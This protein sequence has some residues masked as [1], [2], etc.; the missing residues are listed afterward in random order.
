MFMTLPRD[1]SPARL[2]IDPFNEQ[3]PPV[4]SAS[5]RVLGG[6][7][8]FSS[9]SGTFIAIADAAYRGLP[10]EANAAELPVYDIQLR[11]VPARKHPDN[12]PPSLRMQAGAGLICGMMDESNYLVLAPHNRSALIVASEDLLAIPYY[13]RY[14][15]IEFAVFTLAARCQEMVPLHAACLGLNDRAVLLLGESGAGKST[16][17]LQGLLEG[18]ELL[19]EDA[20]F[21]HPQ[22]LTARGVPNF[23]HLRTDSSGP[24]PGLATQAWIKNA[25]CIV[26]RSGVEKLEVDL[27]GAPGVLDGG[28]TKIAAAVVLSPARARSDAPPLR[29]LSADEARA[30]LIS[31]QPYACSQPGWGI[32]CDRL[33]RKG[34]YELCR[35]TNPR[36]ALAIIQRVLK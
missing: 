17:A 9:N 28:P 31:D 8:R 22:R 29:R 10:Q 14:E 11:L 35:Q 3:T 20:V 15:L 7:F 27:R 5:Y 32:F 16:L 26:R 12:V 1:A 19:A 4:S 33:S 25:R 6:T 23:L 24:I 34:V 30:R 21:V 2:G 36:E 18:F 13:A